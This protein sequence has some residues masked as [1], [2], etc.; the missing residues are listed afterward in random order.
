MVLKR[1]DYDD[2]NRQ[3]SRMNLGINQI[4]EREQEP[5]SERW[6]PVDFVL[7]S[8]ETKKQ[9]LNTI[10]R[11]SNEK[12]RREFASRGGPHVLLISFQKDFPIVYHFQP[13][14]SHS[15]CERAETNNFSWKYI[16]CANPIHH[17]I[18]TMSSNFQS[19]KWR[20]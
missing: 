10:R 17:S 14:L 5:S 11:W 1:S 15:T 19:L 18:Y 3:K 12:A 20:V 13:N 6:S 7:S 4:E 9:L 16:V 8:T 2:S